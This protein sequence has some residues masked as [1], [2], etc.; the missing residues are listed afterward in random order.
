M[1]LTESITLG[2]AFVSTAISLSALYFSVRATKK[3]EKTNQ[4]KLLNDLYNSIGDKTHENNIAASEI[5]V[6]E[7]DQPD[8]HY[9]AKLDR[10]MDHIFGNLN[11]L[12]W[13]IIIKE[14]NNP[15]VAHY[16]DDGIVDYYKNFFLS[17]RNK[18]VREE[19]PEPFRNF[20]SLAKK[21]IEEKEK[22]SKTKI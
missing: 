11:L 8:R 22:E 20:E 4:I 5:P 18:F 3:A 6:D 14:I 16:F 10:M 17:N 1:N 21:I 7:N 19:T 2:L 9:Q 15:E 13:L 12:C